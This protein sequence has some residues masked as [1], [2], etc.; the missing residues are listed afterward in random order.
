M[1]GDKAER[2]RETLLSEREAEVTALRVEGQSFHEIADE[3]DISPQTA[4]TAWQRAKR[5]AADAQQSVEV[6]KDV[7]LLGE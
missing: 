7:G 1:T 6:F 3:L 5:K 2:L 4:N